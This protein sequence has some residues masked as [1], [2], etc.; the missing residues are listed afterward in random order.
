MKIFYYCTLVIICVFLLILATFYLSSSA[1][2]F[3]LVCSL[4]ATFTTIYIG[5]KLFKD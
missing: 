5:Y 2:G 3:T 1:Q 4:A